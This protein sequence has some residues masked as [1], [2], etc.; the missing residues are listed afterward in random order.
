MFIFRYSRAVSI[1]ISQVGHNV[2]KVTPRLHIMVEKAQ[3]IDGVR[4]LCNLG[5]CG[6]FTIIHTLV[7]IA[8]ISILLDYVIVFTNCLLRI[9]HE[10]LPNT[11]FV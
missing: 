9:L 5:S 6:T 11:M 2:H 4:C 8:M 3:F 10:H 7:K 1:M